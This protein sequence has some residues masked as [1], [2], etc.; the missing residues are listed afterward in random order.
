MKK[1]DLVRP[2]AQPLDSITELIDLNTLGVIESFDRVSVNV[3][4]PDGRVLKFRMSDLENL[5]QK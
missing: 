5:D 1:G 4:W 2:S 3:R